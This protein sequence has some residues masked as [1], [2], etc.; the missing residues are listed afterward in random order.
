MEKR[1]IIAIDGY[2]SCGKSTFAKAIARELNYIYIDSGAM[3]RA[4][5]LFCIRKGY[6]GEDYLDMQGI[7]ADLPDIHISFIYNP[8][9]MEYETFLNSENVETVIRGVEVSSHVS[10]ISQIHQVR[11]RMVELQRQIGVFKGIVMDGRDIGTVVFPDADIK[12]FMTAS[13]DIRAK[14][15]YDELKGKNVD[16]EYE[17]IR[18]N[19]IARDIADENRDISPLRRAEDALVLDNSRMTV[20]DQMDWIE[21]IIDK[22]LHG[23]RS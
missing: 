15:R 3:Y 2:S 5:T 17:V 18:N 12:I 22:K 19:I 10:R 6:A 21:K 1:L 23:C 9:R 11:A 8:D 7:L 4:V 14:R 13:V 16:V 20:A